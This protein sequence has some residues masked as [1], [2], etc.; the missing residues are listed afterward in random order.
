MSKFAII[1]CSKCGLIYKPQ[2][3]NISEGDIN[4]PSCEFKENG[5]A[6]FEEHFDGEIVF[7]CISESIKK[8]ATEK[9]GVK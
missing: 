1:E 7:N 6:G 5:I 9:F 4:C 3:A 8:K 2:T